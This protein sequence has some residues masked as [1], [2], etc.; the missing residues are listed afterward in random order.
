MP[1]VA[2]L[3]AGILSRALTGGFEWF[4]PL[5]FLGAAGSLWFYRRSYLSLDWHIDWT[6]PAA[7]LLVFAIWMAL[8]H[9]GSGAMPHDLA[10]SPAG[11]RFGWLTLRVLAATVTVPIAEELA[12]RGYLLRRLIAKDF[13]A[14]SFRRFSWL[15]FVASSAIFGLMHGQRWMAGSLAGAIFAFTVVR[16]GRLGNAVVAHAT[17]NA[18]L[19]MEV[20]VFHRW[21]LW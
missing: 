12:F 13:E 4:Y 3:A 14:V 1:F 7:G 6:A 9:T 2:I 11:L 19:A 5:R 21:E 20:L 17:A 8:D 16:R 10:A 18:L 15:A